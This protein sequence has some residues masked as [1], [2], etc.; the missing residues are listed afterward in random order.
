VDC[1]AAPKEGLIKP[2]H[3]LGAPPSQQVRVVSIN[4]LNNPIPKHKSR[5]LSF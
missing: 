4:T 3:E 2:P 5:T 1:Y